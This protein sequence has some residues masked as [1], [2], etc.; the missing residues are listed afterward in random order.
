[1]KQVGYWGYNNNPED[2][3]KPEW[4]PLE[5]EVVIEYLKAGRIHEAWLGSAYCRMDC[6]GHFGSCDLTDG[7]WIWPEG[8]AHYLEVHQVKPP[9]EFVYWALM[10]S[11]K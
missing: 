10:N 8:Y 1:M 6:K 3:V 7:T 2:F 9:A 4:D 5:R 11:V